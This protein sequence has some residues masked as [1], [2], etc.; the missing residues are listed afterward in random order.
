[1][2]NYDGL[3][4]DS[5]SSGG[6]PATTNRTTSSNRAARSQRTIQ[7]HGNT[8]RNRTRKQQHASASMGQSSEARSTTPASEVVNLVSEGEVQMA[9]PN[10]ALPV[11]GRSIVNVD[12]GCSA[13]M[14]GSI[15]AK[16]SFLAVP[17]KELDI[18]ERITEM[19]ELLAALKIKAGNSEFKSFD[20]VVRTFNANV[21]R[22]ASGPPKRTV[23]R[24]FSNRS[25]F[26]RRSASSCKRKR[27]AEKAITQG[28][29]PRRL[30]TPEITETVTQR[31]QARAPD[32]QNT[33]TEASNKEKEDFRTGLFSH[34]ST[35]YLI[36]WLNTIRSQ[37]TGYY[38][39][40]LFCVS[41]IYKHQ[42]KFYPPE[43]FPESS[44]LQGAKE[45]ALAGGCDVEDT[46][47]WK[48]WEAG[49]APDS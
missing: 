10:L 19:E 42:S 46:M 32:S 31:G 48:E 35:Y 34:K 27:A 25:I 21:E 3:F 11:R 14:K 7:N 41:E 8:H 33:P 38:N 44:V 1:M 36:N 26:I 6:G 16:V 22:I 20:H 45:Q 18:V 12:Q 28:K 40:A 23:A 5:E 30:S 15:P 13:S 43:P 4:D 17:M 29:R 37:S 49:V 39:T 2:L 47:H 24:N 9:I